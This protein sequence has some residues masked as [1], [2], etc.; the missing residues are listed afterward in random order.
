MSHTPKSGDVL[1]SDD[2]ETIVVVEGTDPLDALIDLL[3][4]SYGG[5]FE[6]T[7]PVIVEAASRLKVEV[8]RSC[9]R[10]WCEAEGVDDEGTTGWWAPN[11]DGAREIHAVFYDGS[12]YDLGE[13]AEEAEVPA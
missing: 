3:A 11:G 2:G 8:W 12:V 5:D 7:N 10:D 6:R 13:R 9:T 1:R 4:Y